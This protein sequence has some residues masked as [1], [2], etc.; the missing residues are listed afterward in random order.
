MLI[1]NVFLV[2][3]AAKRRRHLQMHGSLLPHVL[4]GSSSPQFLEFRLTQIMSTD[5]LLTALFGCI[6]VNE[7]QEQMPVRARKLPPR[8]QVILVYQANLWSTCL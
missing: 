4:G 6:A 2:S 1:R 8:P 5:K 7:S 3:Q